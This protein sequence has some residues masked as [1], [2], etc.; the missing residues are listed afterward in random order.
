MLR[1]QIQ[2]PAADTQ[3]LMLSF[4]NL[5]FMRNYEYFNPIEEGFTLFGYELNP[6]LSFMP[7]KY[8]RLEAGVFLRKD[9]G[10]NLYTQVQPTFTLKASK[11]GCSMLIG[12]I[13]GS[14]NHRLIEPLYNF[15]NVINNRL[16]NGGQFLIDKKRIWTDLWIDWQKAIY[17]N[18]PFQEQ[19][20]AG[21]SSRIVAAGAEKDF[22]LIFPVQGLVFHNGGQIEMED[23][24]SHVLTLVNLSPGIILKWNSPDKKNFIQEI[25]TENYWLYYNNGSGT[26]RTAYNSGE[27]IYLNAAVKSRYY[28]EAI[29]SY[30]NGNQFI[31]PMGAP[32][33]QSISSRFSD[34]TEDNRQLLFLRLMYEQ[35]WARDFYV[36][37][38]FEPYYDLNN[39][40]LEYS[41][42]FF[43]TYRKDF[44]LVRLKEKD[45]G[46]N[47]LQRI[48]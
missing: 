35:E 2:M 30:W 33:Y 17:P 37:I 25:R 18:S 16:E 3:R 24:S 15:N 27:G 44:S 45:R 38:R 40:L 36:G 11:N 34:V 42:S 9:F 29:I 48:N 47:S 6:R 46:N 13:E 8:L 5:N 21:L 1:E 10:N 4:S 43:A 12:N 20:W 7:N 32:L 26:K 28:V 19:I 22:K 31:S 39:A 41:Y 23:S 14:L